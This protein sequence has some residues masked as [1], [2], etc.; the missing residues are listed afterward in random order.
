[1]RVLLIDDEPFYYKLLNKPMK[2]AGHEFEYSKT[3]KDGLAKVSATKPDV[4]IVDLRLPDISG[5]DILERLRRDSEFSNIPVIV[6]TARNELG[7]KLKAFELGADDYLVKPFQPEELVARMRILAR[8]GKAMKIVSEMEKSDENLTTIVTV[9]SLRG[10]VGTTSIA[11]NLALAFNQI[12]AKETLLVDAVLSAGQVAMML[13]SKPR[14]TWED[15]AEVETKNIDDDMI[16]DIVGKHSGGLSFIAAPRSPIALDTFSDEFWQLVLGKLAKQ[17]EFIVVDT[18]HDFAD[19]TIQMLNFA[20]ELVLVVAPE[21]SSLRAAMSTLDIY[22]KL[23]FPPE[24]IKVLLNSNSP[25]AGIRRAQIEKVLNHPVDFVIP[26]EPEEVIRAVNFGEPFLLKKPE[27]SIS[28]T[29]ED[30]AY[31]LSHEMHKNL[32]PA[33]PT[34]AWKRVTNRLG[35]N[36]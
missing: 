1:M 25:I 29:I 28:T 24:K 30:M 7:D 22:D 27:L 16:Q 8:R 6:I 10:G 3:G 33:A 32:P 9:H 18:A 12:W 17:Y 31:I 20:S 4:I 2:D 14:Y 11:V 15:F 36:K 34:D 26:Y 23:G 19:I 35:E 21:M 5:H 13:N